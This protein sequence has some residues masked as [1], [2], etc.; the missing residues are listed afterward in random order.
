MLEAGVVQ[1][2]IIMVKEDQSVSPRRIALFSLG[3]LASHEMCRVEM[4]VCKPSAGDLL[5]FIKARN[6][7]GQDQVEKTDSTTNNIDEY[8]IKYAA[9]LKSKLKQGR[10]NSGNNS[11]SRPNSSDTR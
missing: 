3:T 8:I 7:N 2:L 6:S 4:N 1:R 9:R 11:T 10:N 5:R